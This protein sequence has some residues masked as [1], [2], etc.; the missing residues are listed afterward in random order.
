M[1]FIFYLAL[2]AAAV[3]ASAVE[4]REVCLRAVDLGI[5]GR[6]ATEI[7]FLAWLGDGPISLPYRV[8]AKAVVKIPLV[9]GIGGLERYAYTSY[10]LPDRLENNTV[11]CI[12]V[13]NASAPPPGR[14]RGGE[15][16][17]IDGA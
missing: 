2:L 15:L 16:Y 4:L 9:F 8:E 6:G 3:A 10:I 14:D 11:I 13:P 1:R 7:A 5:A 12:S 17:I